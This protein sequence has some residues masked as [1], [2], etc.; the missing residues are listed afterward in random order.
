MRAYLTGMTMLGGVLALGV[1]YAPQAPASPA[2]AA[3]ASLARARA[4]LELVL[5]QGHY[6]IDAGQ[7]ARARESIERALA[8]Q[9]NNPDALGMLCA[10]Q[11][12][13]GDSAAAQLTVNRL[14]AA[15]GGAAQLARLRAALRAGP[16]D[17]K[18][19]AEARKLAGSGSM[20]AAMLRYRALFHDGEPPP[21]LALE[22]YRVLGGTILGY[23]EARARLSAMVAESPY[24][25]NARLAL[26]QVQTYR[27]S[28]R[29]QGLAELRRLAGAD[30]Q[31]LIRTQAIAAWRAT[32]SWVPIVGASIPLYE[33]WLALHPDDAAI[34][35]RLERARAVQAE[36]DAGN[37]RTEGF[38]LLGQGRLDG[39]SAAF[40]RALIASPKDADVLGGL[41]LV[42]QRR[43]R[44][45]AARRLF[46][47]AIAA[48]PAHASHWRA[49]L[50]ALNA[51]G[52]NDPEIVAINRLMA[53]GR[54]DAARR[55][56]AHLA[57]RPEMASASL[58]MTAG[59]D[60][61]QGQPAEAERLYRQA[62]RR[63]PADPDALFNLADLLYQAG[64]VEEAR[65]L[66]ARV[67]ALRPALLPRL[68]AADD[69]VRAAR[70]ETD[71]ERI[72]LLRQALGRVPGD[73]WLILRLAQALYHGGKIAEARRAMEALTGDRHGT[74]ANLQAGVIFAMNRR[75][76]DEAGGLLERLP[77]ETRGPDMRRAAE[78]V[79][80]HRRV[81]AMP[82]EDARSIRA[83]ADQPDPTGD[84]AA[85]LVDA[86]LAR[87]DRDGA[88]WVLAHESAITVS[89]T[90]AQK[91]LYA[92][93]ALRLNAPGDAQRELDGYDRLV[94]AGV[95]R[96]AADAVLA[97][98]DLAVG[99]AIQQSDGDVRAGRPRE[100]YRVI[101]PI[102]GLHPDSVPAWLALGRVYHA[103]KQPRMALRADREALRREPRSV[104]ALAAVTLD[105]LG[106]DDR[107]AARAME[108]RLLANAPRRATTWRIKAEND[109]LD[110]HDRQQEADLVFARMLQC[111]EEQGPACAPAVR[112]KPDYRWPEIETAYVPLRGAPLPASEHYLPQDGPVGSMNRQIVYLHESTSPQLDANT[113]V[114]SRS[115]TVGLGQLTE[116][117]VPVTGTIPFASWRNRVSVSITPTFLFT[118]DP[119]SRA[120]SAARFGTVPLL[121][122][123]F[124]GHHAY[125]AQGVGLDI[126]YVDHWF[127]AD[128]G[129]SPLGFPIA[130]VLGG[131][132]F[133]PRLTDNLTLRITGDRRM[134]T[135]SELS[136]AGM[137]DPGTGKVWGGVTRIAGHGSLEWANE[138]W[139]AYAGGGFAFLEGSHVAGNTE[140]DAAL[141]G[142]ATVW[143]RA[144]RQRLRLGLDAEY[145]GYRRNEYAFTLGQGG[146]FSPQ[147][148]FAVMPSLDYSGHV[149]RWTWSVRGA[150]G[151]QN[152]HV[153]GAPYFPLDPDMQRMMAVP[154][155]NRF[156]SQ[157]ASGV[158]GSGR[159]RIVYQ[160]T[161]G[162]RLGI[163]GGYIRS[164]SW[165]EAS[166]MLMA[167]YQFGGP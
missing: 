136:Y 25:L 115:G 112:R 142:S 165:S 29:A 122:D 81:A 101:A 42:A 22:Y 91:L 166:G 41:G 73:P 159:A 12:G 49:A 158:A 154:G 138:I 147:S 90:P 56:L 26:A 126:R 103:L 20:L 71:A 44:I 163:E 156:D 24:D 141:G 123:R 88:L 66:A 16:V 11:I 96:Q 128:V 58:L 15:G 54:Y 72:G 51:K 132:E 113:Y 61:L 67:A 14:A 80:F 3:D 110:G 95:V 151:Y 27:D 13:A 37:G 57:R 55:A 35:T 5:E 78:L 155:P 28:S 116:L 17:P 162:L 164:G 97:R 19:L 6:W 65:V 87:H 100:A 149:D 76:Y 137:R 18:G 157:G 8:I 70:A 77:V 146:Y 135:D 39:A 68:Q 75:D 85:I 89:P 121:G 167:H 134:V 83:L 84:R 145:M 102:V 59:L 150:V 161:D 107:P 129:A 7:L 160:V 144:H 2:P 45:A 60:R 4:V 143:E 79:A 104:D 1:A 43:N 140:A 40:Q 117:A 106:L 139:N 47:Q 10:V 94:R 48:D 30:T 98:A 62:L 111:S 114:R 105:A 21:A 124:G 133:A 69:A 46:Q 86:L 34:V 148:Y 52:G 99:V 127:A 131:V 109:R 93:L 153:N 23:N 32:L 118:G 92:G 120:Y 50:T 130:N 152:Y 38:V 74:A 82:M 125:D 108:R 119:L 53:A 63:R 31:P 33:D 64:Q 9:P 36:I